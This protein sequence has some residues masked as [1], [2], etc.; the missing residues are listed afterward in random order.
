MRSGKERYHGPSAPA[1][2]IAVPRTHAPLWPRIRASQT[3][4]VFFAALW[5]DNP[6]FKQILGICSALAVTNLAVNTAVMC[7]AVIFVQIC[8]SV[9]YSVVR[10]VT[11]VR[12]R[13]LVQML[14][15]ASMVIL[16]HRFLQAQV[17][18]VSEQI[19][20]YVGLII[21][22]CIILGRLEAFAAKNT[23]YL[24]MIDGFGSALG[25][26]FVLMAVAVPREILGFHSL[27]GIQLIP[28][29]VPR[30][31]IMVM[32]PAGFFGIGVVMWVCRGIQMRNEES[33]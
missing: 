32:A 8:S 17:F 23:P 2:G 4:K 10:T 25:Y 20:A 3:W 30:W 24:S 5:T 21:T 12:T 13:M 11:P 9:A 29:T 31:N 6:I 27:F 14:I 16:V 26:A 18:S 28:D 15:I 1:P 22:N 19:G 33:K 7:F